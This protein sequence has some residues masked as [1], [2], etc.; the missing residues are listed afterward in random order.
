ML[1]RAEVAQ[2]RVRLAGEALQKR[3]REPRF[4]DTC[5]AREE[6]HLTFAGLC[7]RPASQQ[8]FEF[9]L[10]PD[11]RG[12]S[13]RVQRLEAAFHRAR[14]QRSP[15]SHRPSDALEVLCSEVLKL[16][17]IAEQFSCALGANVESMP[18]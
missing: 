10:P 8:Q 11:E 17:Q 6:H 14:P 5:L 15:G 13:A 12:Q 2:A 9:F 16:E 1:R 7:L 18:S 4:A 3:S